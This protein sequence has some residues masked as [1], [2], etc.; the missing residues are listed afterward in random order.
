MNNN[1]YYLIDETQL[2]LCD[3]AEIVENKN[4]LT[5]RGT[6]GMY[7]IKTKE[8]MT[9]EHLSKV[10]SYN[11]SEIKVELAKAKYQVENINID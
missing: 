7:V 3:H 1:T 8:G 4:T 6:S 2:D 11:H 9:C 10:Q 5:P